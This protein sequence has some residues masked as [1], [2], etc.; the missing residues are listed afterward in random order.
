M[1]IANDFK[2]RFE[3]SYVEDH[4][5]DSIRILAKPG[6][7]RINSK[8]FNN[9][10]EEHC[11][12]ISRKVL[13]GTYNFIPY[14]EVLIMKGR[15]KSPRMIS[16]PAIRDKI[17][18][19]IIKDILHD[20]FSDLLYSEFVKKKIY[21]VSECFHSGEYDAFIKIDMRDFYGSLKHEILLRKLW[22]KARKPEFIHIIQSAISNPTISQNDNK[23]NAVIPDVGVPQGLPI[24]NILS[25]IYMMDFDN[26]HTES[27]N[28]AYFR[29]VD[30][31]LIL[32]KRKDAGLIFNTL[33][34]ELIMDLELNPHPLG[35]DNQKTHLGLI[36]EGFSY[37]GYQFLPNKVTVRK[38]S[39]LK[40][41]RAIEGLFNEYK[42]SN[43]PFNT[44]MWK[45]NLKIT[46][47]IF[48]ENTY[49]WLFYYSQIDDETLMFQFDQFILKLFKRYK[50]RSKLRRSSISLK[51]FVRAYN[52]MKYNREW[53]TYIPDFDIV[54]IDEKYD[55]LKTCKI[56]VK[57]ASD[58]D[59]I[60]YLFDNFISKS[61]KELERDRGSIS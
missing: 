59:E 37:L 18:L 24:S 32:C 21:R 33:K 35:K 61:M 34:N 48:N 11:N 56:S 29:Y 51:R 19:S 2:T 20:Q 1:G 5:K 14:K 28:Y 4:F 38:K 7:D 50:L 45:L 40:I 12:L 39:K 44:F 46:G 6:I 17:V 43:I 57:D 10:L 9:N 15:N 52:E 22:K 13:E 54:S 30:D 3:P 58:E 49:G 53:T 41:E 27:D 60:N 31:I 23:K 16:I 8:K 26:Q 25:D 36:K 42:N 47:A 55:I